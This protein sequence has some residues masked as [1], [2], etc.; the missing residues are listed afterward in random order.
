MG[1]SLQMKVVAEGVETK[2]QADFLRG[3]GCDEIQGYLLEPAAA[4]AAAGG[5]A[6]GTAPASELARPALLESVD[7]PR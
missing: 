3:L 1:H 4:G 2:E 7:E 5:V 6:V